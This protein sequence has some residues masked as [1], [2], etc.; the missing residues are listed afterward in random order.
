MY[1]RHVGP[2]WYIG[3]SCASQDKA[4]MCVDEIQVRS[5]GVRL[6]ARGVFPLVFRRLEEFLLVLPGS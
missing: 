4:D 5:D 1:N 6:D 2:I 3:R